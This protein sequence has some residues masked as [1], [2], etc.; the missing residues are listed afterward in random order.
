MTHYFARHLAR[1]R[2]PFSMST[3]SAAIFRA[4]LLAHVDLRVDDKSGT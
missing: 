1:M 3:V 4:R 2:E